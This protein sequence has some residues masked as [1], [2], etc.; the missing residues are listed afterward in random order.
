MSRPMSSSASP[1]KERQ[2]MSTWM[3]RPVFW[4]GIAVGVALIITSLV[5]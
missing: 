4:F 2:Q 3:S 1:E 5:S